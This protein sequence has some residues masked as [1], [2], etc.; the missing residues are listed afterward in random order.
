MLPLSM[1]SGFFLVFCGQCN[2]GVLVFERRLGKADTGTRSWGFHTVRGRVDQGTT[3][4]VYD[5]FGYDGIAD[6]CYTAH[7]TQIKVLTTK[8]LE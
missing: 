2:T 1:L 6:Q 3:L 7:K 4:F 8:T 5:S